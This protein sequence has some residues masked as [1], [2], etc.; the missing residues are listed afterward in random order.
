MLASLAK[1]YTCHDR[2]VPVRSTDY[3]WVSPQRHITIGLYEPRS[4]NGC[5]TTLLVALQKTIPADVADCPNLAAG[6]C[7]AV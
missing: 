4:S 3:A 1:I 5:S 2:D 7:A 6:N